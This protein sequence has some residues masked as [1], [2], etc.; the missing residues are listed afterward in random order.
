MGLYTNSLFL[1]IRLLGWVA[2]TQNVIWC[3]TG[4]SLKISEALCSNSFALIDGKLKAKCQSLRGL[5]RD[6]KTRLLSEISSSSS[7]DVTFQSVFCLPFF[8]HYFLFSHLDAG[9]KG[10]SH[11]H[12]AAAHQLKNTACPSTISLIVG[13]LWWSLWVCLSPALCVNRALRLPVQA[14]WSICVYRLHAQTELHKRRAR[15]RKQTLLC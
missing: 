5:Q 14:L 12:N 15:Q 10:F 1:W 6:K 11:V 13:R 9:P 8:V 2:S 4:D 3:N 7:V